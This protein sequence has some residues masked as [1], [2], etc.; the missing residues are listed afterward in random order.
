[1]KKVLLAIILIISIGLHGQQ[2]IVVDNDTVSFDEQYLTT[3]KVSGDNVKTYEYGYLNK[4]SGW[5]IQYT[6]YYLEGNSDTLIV[7]PELVYITYWND[8]EIIRDTWAY[9]NTTW[10]LQDSHVSSFTNDMQ[11]LYMYN[12]TMWVDLF[13]DVAG[14]L[15]RLESNDLIID[16]NFD[17]QGRIDIETHNDTIVYGY[18]YTDKVEKILEDYKWTS[19]ITEDFTTIEYLWWNTL[20]NEWT[21]VSEETYIGC[22]FYVRIPEIVQR[23]NTDERYYNILGQEIKKPESGFYIT[24]GKKY[25]IH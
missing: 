12:D 6:L 25:F 5:D 8:D 20:L 23:I 15:Y 3:V 22:W 16:Y 24:R 4:L 7:N 11:P 21:G 17:S 10:N 19:E 13:Y 1:M 9:G 14:G 18:E 2:C